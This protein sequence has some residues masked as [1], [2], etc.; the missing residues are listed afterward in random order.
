M[1]QMLM[2][3]WLP[4]AARIAGLKQNTNQCCPP[5]L[6]AGSFTAAGQQLI[7]RLPALLHPV[8]QRAHTAV[9]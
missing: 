7:L 1:E 4:N 2:E 9:P 5:S 8:A 6:A 3:A